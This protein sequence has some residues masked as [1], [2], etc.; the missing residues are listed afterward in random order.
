M[1]N[2]GWTRKRFSRVKLN[3]PTFKDEKAKD[4]VTYGIHGIGMCPCSTALVG[5]TATCCPLSLGLCKDIQEDIARSLGED[6][7]LGNVLQMLDEHYG[8]VITFNA[9][10]KKLFSLK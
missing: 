7:T 1:A 2:S 3:L 8:V 5:M 9:S 4:T 10:S 6:A